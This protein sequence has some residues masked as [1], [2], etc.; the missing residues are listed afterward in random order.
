MILDEPTNDLDIATI[1][2][3]EEYL[4]SFGGAI[5]LVSHDRYFVDKIATKLYAFE[6]NGYIN[7]LHTLYTEYLENEKEVE[8]LDNFALELQTQEQNNNQKEKS[9]KKL[10][11]KENKIL[12]NHPEKIDFLEQKIAKLN[13]NLSNPNVYQEVGINKLYQELEAMQKELE[14][15]ENEYFLV[16]EKSENL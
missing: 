4:L 2:I 6:G 9:S 5:L 14:I 10:S 12:K 11:Y 13:Q 16:L 8:E 3:L 1:N 15:L 7:I